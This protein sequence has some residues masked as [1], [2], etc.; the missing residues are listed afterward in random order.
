[1]LLDPPPVPLEMYSDAAIQASIATLEAS[2]AYTE[3][4]ML[5]HQPEE[6]AAHAPARDHNDRQVLNLRTRL[7]LYKMLLK[8]RLQQNMRP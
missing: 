5:E 6:D 1:M 2:E 3:I 8:T 7:P 4:L